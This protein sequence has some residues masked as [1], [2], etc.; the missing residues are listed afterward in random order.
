[1]TIFDSVGAAKWNNIV[2]NLEELV[3]KAIQRKGD[4]YSGVNWSNLVHT[5]WGRFLTIS[6]ETQMF[7]L[8]LNDLVYTRFKQEGPFIR[9]LGYNLHET[10]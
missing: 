1:M 5:L 7:L 2:D 9:F 3:H 10:I 6:K 4:S 8:K